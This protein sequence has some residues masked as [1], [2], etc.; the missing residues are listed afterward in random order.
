MRLG[1]DEP[2]WEGFHA[3]DVPRVSNAQVI[4]RGSTA[5]ARRHPTFHLRID[6]TRELRGEPD[7]GGIWLC[8]FTEILVT[9]R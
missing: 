2:V 4:G 6:P 1:N 9:P 3:K 5:A 8:D 7:I